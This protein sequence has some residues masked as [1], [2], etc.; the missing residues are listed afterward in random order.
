MSK[1]ATFL[2]SQ[3]GRKIATGITGIGLVLFII[4]H[5]I[6]NLT[7]FA[8]ADAINTYSYTLHQMGP[9]LWVVRLGLLAFFL[10]HA[11]L[12]LSIWLERRRARPEGYKVHASRGEPSRQN[13]SSRSMIITG[14]LLL[15]FVIT[16]LNTFAFHDFSTAVVNGVEMHDVHER[17]TE[18]FSQP[19]YTVYYVII[20]VLLGMHL[21]HGVWSA[22]QS[23][24]WM[25]RR[26]NPIIYS[27]AFV[28]ALIIAIG[29]IGL[30]ISIYIGQNF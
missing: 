6:G 22:F 19:G 4:V 24:G 3:V 26:T 10:Y 7:Y 17:L 16:H 18:V 14:V 13:W 8:G 20:M 30:P 27:I 28:L 2:N 11:W 29:F 23:L 1:A 25:S 9:L 15:L 21:R 12:G 5:L